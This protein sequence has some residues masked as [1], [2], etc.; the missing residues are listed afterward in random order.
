MAF[1]PPIHNPL[2]YCTFTH[3]YKVHIYKYTYSTQYML[4]R[5][6]EHWTLWFH[7]NVLA[8]KPS[9]HFVKQCDKMDLTCFLE[10]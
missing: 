6:I 7:T 3:M 2:K 4:I 8:I 9:H 1:Y 10:L 5:G